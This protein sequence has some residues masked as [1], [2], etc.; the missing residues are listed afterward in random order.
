[1]YPSVKARA[2]IEK[3]NNLNGSTTGRRQ[4]APDNNIHDDKPSKSH[5]SERSETGHSEKS[6][7]DFTEEQLVAVKRI[8]KC[9]DYYEILGITKD[10]TDA[11]LKKAYRKLAL[12][13][14]PDKNKAPGATEAFKA[15][16][17][18]F[19]V[20]SD[21]EKRKKY[22]LY[23]EDVSHQIRTN[24]DGYDHYDYS[25]GFEGDISAEEL[26]NM[27]F[28]GGFPSGNV[29]VHRRN[30][31]GHFQRHS[32]SES[33]YGLLTQLAPVL[34]LIFLSLMGSFLVPDSPFSL[35]HSVKY[36]TERLTNNLKVP[37]FV[38]DDFHVDSKYDLRRIERQVEEEYVSNLRTSCFKEK[39]YKET[40]MWRAKNYGDVKLYEKAGNLDTPSCKRL[41]SLYG[42]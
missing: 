22:D 9:K 8:K 18:A 5:S 30:Q 2:L 37:Y 15:I 31:N 16:G 29:Y 14:H 21:P 36:S 39:S 35:Q 25:R 4:S 33:G 28:G 20:L 1:M 34:M 6:V 11:D 26:F 7:D 24:R 38:K 12:K 3:L 41:N 42:G 19:S 17:N 23:G 27:F 32:H 10:A 13:M 40:M